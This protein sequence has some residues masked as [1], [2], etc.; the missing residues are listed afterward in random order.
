MGMRRPL[1]GLKRGG[2]AVTLAGVVWSGFL[3]WSY[4]AHLTAAEKPSWWLLREAG[5]ADPK[6]CIAAM[7]ELVTR[8]A[9]DQLSLKQR[10]TLADRVLD[11]LAGSMFK[12][13][14]PGRFE[15]FLD[16]ELLAGELR[17]DQINRH[18]PTTSWPEILISHNVRRGEAIEM[19]LNGAFSP[20][21]R[22]NT[23]HHTTRLVSVKVDGH[24]C[25]APD[26]NEGTRYI[27]PN[28]AIQGGGTGPREFF[29]PPPVLRELKDGAH[30]IEAVIDYRV[31]GE[32][33]RPKA[34]R[35]ELRHERYT[36]NATFNL[37]PAGSPLIKLVAPEDQRQAVEAALR[38]KE[39]FWFPGPEERHK[40]LGFK[41]DIPDDFEF[42]VAFRVYARR[43]ASEWELGRVIKPYCWEKS[44][45][46]ILRD[47]EWAVGFS[48][49]S[50]DIVL[51]P[52]LDLAEKANDVEK[53]WGGE[54]VYKDV[55]VVRGVRPH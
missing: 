41:F 43:G 39:I 8:S 48:G 16:D 26:L 6:V 19:E 53:I 29:I 15:G 42:P 36:S 51:R 5:G 50:V 2:W 40:F 46:R 7:N 52:A 21:L 12:R 32:R 24:E 38:P 37:V 30:R 35:K 25:P 23:S 45:S 54:I 13:V 28:W 49:D 27:P 10:V 3:V 31:E 4:L 17:A 1:V 34:E 47:W 9:K 33:P 20:I 11:G 18:W 44:N 14:A 55:P 22:R